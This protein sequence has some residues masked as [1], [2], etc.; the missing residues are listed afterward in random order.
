MMNEVTDQPR[1]IARAF[2]SGRLHSRCAVSS[3]RCRSDQIQTR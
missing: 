2:A 1:C 3:H